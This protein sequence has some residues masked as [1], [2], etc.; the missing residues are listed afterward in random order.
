LPSEPTA[1]QLADDV[2]ETALSTGCPPAP[3]LGT[4]T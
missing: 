4:E 3:G 2:Q 1:Q